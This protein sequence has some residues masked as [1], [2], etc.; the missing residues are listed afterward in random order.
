M[1]RPIGVGRQFPHIAD[2][3]EE[4]EGVGRIAARGRETLETVLAGVHH[5]KQALPGIGQL[6]LAMITAGL[7]LACTRCPLP[8]GL[9]RQFP[10]LPARIGAGVLEGHGHNGER[11]PVAN[12]GA[13]AAGVSPLCAWQVAPP[14]GQAAAAGDFVRHHKHHSARLPHLGRQPALQRWINGTL[15][16]GDIA[17]GTHESGKL[18]VGDLG[19]VHPEAS[20]GRPAQ[21]LLFGIDHITQLETAAGHPHHARVHKVYLTGLLFGQRA[22]ESLRGGLP[23]DV[24]APIP[25]GTRRQQHGADHHADQDCAPSTRTQEGGHFSARKTAAPKPDGSGRLADHGELPGIVL[26]PLA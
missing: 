9:G 10:T 5:R 4:A 6:G 13:R 24:A 8:L 23:G 2:H 20:D 26:K 3:V 22:V 19:P 17:R 16:H 12:A 21:R 7:M 15:S 14:L 11:V 1:G 25:Q 18:L